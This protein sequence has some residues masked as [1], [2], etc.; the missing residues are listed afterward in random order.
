MQRLWY[1]SGDCTSLYLTVGCVKLTT[2]IC[3]C[4]HARPCHEA[5]ELVGVLVMGAGAPCGRLSPLPTA[6]LRNGRAATVEA[7]SRGAPR[8]GE[9]QTHRAHRPR[10]P[11]LAV[12]ALRQASDSCLCSVR[13]RAADSEGRARRGRGSRRTVPILDSLVPR[14]SH[15][16][17]LFL[18]LQAA[19][20]RC[21]RYG[22]GAPRP[23]LRGGR[24]QKRDLIGWSCAATWRGEERL[25]RR[26]SMQDE[27]GSGPASID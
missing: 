13:G 1:F 24:T 19:S 14:R 4:A 22:P 26:H 9:G 5:G 21:S 2:M 25:W 11:A 23:R 18:H 16:E 15:E 27:A 7:T 8:G 12:A 10:T 6:S 17:I 20:G 3:V